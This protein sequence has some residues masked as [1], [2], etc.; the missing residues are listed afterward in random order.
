MV[1]TANVPEYEGVWLDEA[2]ELP[3]RNLFD[4]PGEGV[5]MYHF[6]KNGETIYTIYAEGWKDA[7]EGVSDFSDFDELDE[8]W[9]KVDSFKGGLTR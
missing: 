8:L 2:P 6:R 3:R 4:R 9:I 7:V 1:S 5:A